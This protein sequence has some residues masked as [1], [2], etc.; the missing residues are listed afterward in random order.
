MVFLEICL[1][2][3]TTQRMNSIVLHPLLC[4]T[5]NR[6]LISTNVFRHKKDSWHFAAET[7]LVSL[8]CLH[9]CNL[10][11]VFLW[12]ER[13]SPLRLVSNDILF[14]NSQATT[15]FIKFKSESCS[16]NLGDSSECR[17]HPIC[18]CQRADPC[19]ACLDIPLDI[20]TTTLG[21][22]C[23]TPLKNPQTPSYQLI[24]LHH[25]FWTTFW[26][27]QFECD[28]YAWSGA[29]GK[30]AG[31]DFSNCLCT[32]CLLPRHFWTLRRIQILRASLFL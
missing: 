32:V 7:Q 5:T 20:F 31:Y 29:N 24:L 1:V 27:E 10:L 13:R 25:N 8:R 17:F 4:T 19:V 6:H 2:S 28:A 18:F 14:A 3:W 21:L 16:I 12:V 9:R 26:L 11:A 23:S 22:Q 30:Y 15:T